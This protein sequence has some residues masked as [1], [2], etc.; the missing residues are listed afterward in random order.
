MKRLLLLF[1]ALTLSGCLDATTGPTT[2]DPATETFATSLGV[3]ISQMTKTT[4]GTY[5]K[6]EFVGT[7][8]QLTTPQTTTSVNVD[9]S[10]Y[11]TNGT[12]FDTNTGTSFPLGGVI[13]GFVDGMIGMRVGGTRLIVIPSALGYQNSTQTTPRATI[14]PNSTLV[15]RIKLNSFTQ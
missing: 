7:G 3:N 2:S 4:A 1:G 10:G 14:P 9:Y 8:T 5:Y 12:L 6:D 15:F 13:V 11:L